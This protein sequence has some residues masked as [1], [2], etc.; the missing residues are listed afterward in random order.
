MMTD[1]TVIAQRLSPIAEAGKNMTTLQTLVKDKP[2]P[3]KNV[4]QTMAGLL[5]RSSSKKEEE[6]KA[7]DETEPTAAKDDGDEDGESLGIL[8]S[9]QPENSKKGD[10]TQKDDKVETPTLPAVPDKATDPTSQPISKG[11]ADDAPLTPSKDVITETKK[12]EPAEED[13]P[14]AT[15]TL[16]TTAS[17]KELPVDPVEPMDETKKP[18]PALEDSSTAPALPEKDIKSAGD[19][20]EGTE[21]GEDAKPSAETPA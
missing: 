11:S 6:G 15:E 12:L 1:V 14:I 18:P 10:E 13:E 3:R 16:A 2:V 5:K 17:E 4:S 7:A 8:P 19:E 9:D 21:K 20:L